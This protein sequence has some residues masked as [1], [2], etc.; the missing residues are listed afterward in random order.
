MSLDLS[1]TDQKL[2]T[3]AIKPGTHIP[4][5]QTGSGS[6]SPLLVEK[7]KTVQTGSG[8]TGDKN[9]APEVTV[10]ELKKQLEEAKQREA[11][12]KQ[13]EDAVS[14]KEKELE[15]KA[16]Q[17]EEDEEHVKEGKETVARQQE[18]VDKRERE[19]DKKGQELET[20]KKN[21]ETETK[22]LLAMQKTMDERYADVD[23]STLA[24]R[25]EEMLK[26]VQDGN[27]KY[28]E[29]Q[30]KKMLASFDSYLKQ[31]RKAMDE[32]KAKSNTAGKKGLT[33]QDEILYRSQI[34]QMKSRAIREYIT[35]TAGS[36]EEA[37]KELMR[38]E[39]RMLVRLRAMYRAFGDHGHVEEMAKAIDALRGAL[40][41]VDMSEVEKAMEDTSHQI[42]QEEEE[43]AKKEKK[44]VKKEQEGEEDG[45]SFL[46]R[47]EREQY[48]KLLEEEE[49]EKGLK[50]EDQ[51]GQVNDEIERMKKS[52]WLSNFSEQEKIWIVVYGKI[53]NYQ[54]RSVWLAA[55]KEKNPD[56]Q[57]PN[58][59]QLEACRKT[60][61]EKWEKDHDVKKLS[62]KQQE[63][64]NKASRI[65]ELEEDKGKEAE[66]MRLCVNGLHDSIHIFVEHKPRAKMKAGEAVSLEAAHEVKEGDAL[67][68]YEYEHQDRG[69][70]CWSVALASL[71][72]FNTAD[73]EKKIRQGDVRNVIPVFRKMAAGETKEDFEE[74]QKDIARFTTENKAVSHM[75]NI[76]AMSDYISQQVKGAAVRHMTVS[77][78]KCKLDDSRNPNKNAV[79]NVTEVLK[80]TIMGAIRNKQPIAMLKGSH[81][82]VIVSADAD[83]VSMLNSAGDQ[84]HIDEK[85]TYEELMG[86]NDVIELTWL[87]T[88]KLDGL[89][90]EFK[91]LKKDEN[92]GFSSDSD[93]TTLD[94]DLVAVNSGLVV[95]KK[96]EDLPEDVRD[97]ISERVYVP[98]QA[99]QEEKPEDK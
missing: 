98:K 4:E 72:N 20:R 28:T 34:I 26:R 99:K 89:T 86:A 27:Q 5:Q 15:K 60:I 96:A 59:D 97:Y 7:K 68:G 37:S 54:R 1:K 64:F 56:F 9:E 30:R 32:M 38:E 81:Y 65:P 24:S 92:G 41:Q 21:L 8:L 83:G 70:D 67:K 53:N 66:E 58:K 74:A 40:L 46:T 42:G 47:E 55:Y 82:R 35:M 63:L 52:P 94:P 31:V 36:D 85:V 91:S 61:L 3:T 25:R 44:K 33:R 39:I 11:A 78:P 50:K 90:K 48:K 80:D 23:E 12:L 14:E 13:R 51:I 69:N 22:S 10:E 84:A 77:V 43:E 57:E 2:E 62:K 71:V 17:I 6:D 16:K 88:G 19:V 29:K 93:E 79:H 87:Q 49:K 75:G 95:H 76:F 45:L 18:E 73:P